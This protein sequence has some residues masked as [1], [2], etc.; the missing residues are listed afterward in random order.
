MV[1]G[2]PSLRRAS[3]HEESASQGSIAMICSCFVVDL[4]REQFIF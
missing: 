3:G 4:Y 1:G 2:K